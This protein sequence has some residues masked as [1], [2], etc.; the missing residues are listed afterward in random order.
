M[1]DTL[2]EIREECQR[3][4]REVPTAPIFWSNDDIDLYINDGCLDIAKKVGCLWG[5]VI[6][7]P[8]GISSFT[9]SEDTTISDDEVMSIPLTSGSSYDING[10]TLTWEDGGLIQWF[11]DENNE[12]NQKFTLPSDVLEIPR[13]RVVY[14]EDNHLDF[15]TLVLMDEENEKWESNNPGTPVYWFQKDT[16]HIYVDPPIEDAGE[17]YANY[18][19]TGRIVRIEDPDN[20]YTFS[21]ELG[22]IV[23]IQDDNEGGD[24][25]DFDYE[26]G[27]ITRIAT[28]VG[29]LSVWYKKKPNELINDEDSSEIQEIFKYALYSY[30]LWKA[31]S[32]KSEA[33]N[34]GTAKIYL[35]EYEMQLLELMNVGKG[36]V[37]G[38][39]ARLQD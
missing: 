37:A 21:S 23:R 15:K 4:L 29:N 16:R 36:M 9:M 5:R 10:Y 32:E 35:Q 7:N 14:D 18:F 34:I 1:E 28:P 24:C 33:Q 22:R 26:L 20:T 3:R 12:D 31:L 2:Q 11:E 25:Y 8:S 17:I 19:N 30:V 6:F 39:Q 27:L 13:K 38:H